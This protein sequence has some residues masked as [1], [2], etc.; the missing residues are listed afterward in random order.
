MPAMNPMTSWLT[1]YV[2]DQH[3]ALDSVPLAE[4]E[5]LTHTLRR[6]WLADAQEG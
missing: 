5:R 6:A 1:S 3:R 2:A 4:I